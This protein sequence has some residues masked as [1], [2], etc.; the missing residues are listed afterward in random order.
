MS[1]KTFKKLSAPDQRKIEAEVRMMLHASRDCLRN[2]KIDTTKVPW[3]C[4]DGYY[5]EAFGI[6]RALAALGYGDFGSDNVPN[7][8]YPLWNLKYWFR[9][10]ESTVL[11]EEHF[12]GTNHCDHCLDRYEK[13]AVRRRTKRDG[14]DVILPWSPVP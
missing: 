1:I 7:S 2:Q 9:Q 11:A 13:D 3:D 5:G 12:G 6:M 10:I 4:R 8:I 14:V